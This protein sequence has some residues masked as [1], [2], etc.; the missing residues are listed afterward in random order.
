MEVLTLECVCKTAAWWGRT[1][2]CGLLVMGEATRYVSLEQRRLKRN[3]SV[4]PP[5]RRALLFSRRW[6][7]VRR[8]I[9]SEYEEILRIR[10]VHLNGQHQEVVSSVSK[11]RMAFRCFKGIG[12]C[13]WSLCCALSL[14]GDLRGP[15]QVMVSYQGIMVTTGL[16]TVQLWGAEPTQ[17]HQKPLRPKE[18]TELSLT[19]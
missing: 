19:T 13:C 11:G 8:Q 10:A 1:E 5:F 17:D 16:P 3:K 2:N 4:R 14:T 6:E 18:D 15:F 9:S 7:I 12:C